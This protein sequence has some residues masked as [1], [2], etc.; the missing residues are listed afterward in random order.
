V[1]ESWSPNRRTRIQLFLLFRRR[2]APSVT[3]DPTEPAWVDLKG[4]SL[5]AG[6]PLYALAR[7]AGLPAGTRGLLRLGLALA[8]LTWLPLFVLSAVQHL[9]LGGSTVSFLESLG[10]HVR[11]LL[12]IPLFF[13]AE[14]WFDERARDVVDEMLESNLV[15]PGEVPRFARALQ[16]VV[17]WREAWVIEVALV[18]LTIGL[19]VSGVR[20]DLPVDV[21]T[22]RTVAGETPA[23]LSLAGWWY[24]VFSLPVF[25]FL[26]WRWCWRL[27]VWYVFLW[28]LA[29]L[30]L[31][32]IPTHPD[33][34]GGLGGLGVAHTAFSAFSFAVSAMLVASFAEDI[35]FGGAQ[36]QSFVLQLAGIVVGLTCSFSRH[37]SSSSRGSWPPSRE[38][39]P[40]TARWLRPTRGP[41]TASGCGAGPG[42][43]R[44]SSAP[45]TSSRSPISRIASR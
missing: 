32:L 4:F 28:R 20:A 14:A 39:S 34:A 26:L 42:P 8:A 41:S 44:P 2:P 5:V 15:K 10:T 1:S 35:L 45:P 30:D 36:A 6:G 17:R 13:V 27:L 31:Q 19:I 33:G 22:W 25:Q 37:S 24:T 29:R 38:A 21:T 18:V 9:V 43:R 3:G 11:F 40:S 23:R 7:R 16:T 12:A